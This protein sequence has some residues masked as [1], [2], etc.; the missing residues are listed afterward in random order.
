MNK[1][2]GIHPQPSP[3]RQPHGGQ[4]EWVSPW[5][6]RDEP[7][8][9][10]AFWSWRLHAACRGLNT[11][12]FYS[13]EGERGLARASR[14]RAAKAICATCP[15]KAPCAAYALQHQ[16]RYGVWGGL[17][18]SDRAA[19]WSRQGPTPRPIEQQSLRRGRA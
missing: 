5:R 2:A 4:P 12:L 3:W 15:V 17:T 10:A 19:R 7:V 9:L 18:E 6:D 8:F 13:P 1:P 11:E 16:E 14:E